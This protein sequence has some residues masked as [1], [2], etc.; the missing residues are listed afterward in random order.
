MKI[1]SYEETTDK[2]SRTFWFSTW[3]KAH[4]YIPLWFEHDSNYSFKI[5]AHEIKPTKMDILHLLNTN[6]K[7]R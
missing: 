7:K 2:G 3:K 6:G 4:K 1:Y 5:E